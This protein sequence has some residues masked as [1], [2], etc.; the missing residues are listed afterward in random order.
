MR[1]KEILIYDEL[2][3]RRLKNQPRLQTDQAGL[4]HTAP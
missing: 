2:G 4:S 3:Q 1:D